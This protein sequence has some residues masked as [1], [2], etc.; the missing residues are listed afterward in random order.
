MS[1]DH[2]T[3]N[4]SPEVVFKKGTGVKLLGMDLTVDPYVVEEDDDDRFG[5]GGIPGRGE[6]DGDA[7]V[8][9]PEEPAGV[10]GSDAEF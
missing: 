9:E 4:I 5:D 2:K 10:L 1:T 3:T 7:I 6:T 8:C